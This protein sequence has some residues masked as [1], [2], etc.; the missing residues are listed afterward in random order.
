[1]LGKRLFPVNLAGTTAQ[2]Y[3]LRISCSRSGTRP[4][5]V[6]L[7]RRVVAQVAQTWLMQVLT[8]SSAETTRCKDVIEAPTNPLAG[9]SKIPAVFLASRAMQGSEAVLQI[10]LPEAG[11]HGTLCLIPFLATAIPE[12]ARDVPRS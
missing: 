12:S 7:D 3:R 4:V 5:E 11:Q 1:M 2:R 8:A 6:Y 10:K 9:A